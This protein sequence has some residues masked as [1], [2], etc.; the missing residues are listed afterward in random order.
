MWPDGYD[1]SCRAVRVKREQ[2]S[3]SLAPSIIAS[4]GIGIRPACTD[5]NKRR[6]TVRN[7]RR[8]DEHDP[9]DTSLKRGSD[10]VARADNIGAFKTRPWSN[11]RDKTGNVNHRISTRH[12]STN[13][14][15]VGDIPVSLRDT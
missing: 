1:S 15:S 6:T 10:D 9:S 4:R 8:R 12:S 2:L 7:R 13:S 11:G 5:T 3:L 14:D